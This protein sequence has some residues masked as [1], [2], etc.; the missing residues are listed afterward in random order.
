[1][2]IRMF[3]D[4]LNAFSSLH[5]QQTHSA[6]PV[7]R[8]AR[9][10]SATP[11]TTAT[12]GASA[13]PQQTSPS[14]LLLQGAT[15]ATALTARAARLRRSA[16]FPT[17]L[18][19]QAVERTVRTRARRPPHRLHGATATRLRGATSSIASSAH[20]DSASYT[21]AVPLTPSP[22]R[23]LLSRIFRPRRIRA[24]IAATR[25]AASASLAFFR[26]T[27]TGV[28]ARAIIRTL[29]TR[30]TLPASRSGPTSA[31]WRTFAYLAGT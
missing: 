28:L 18:A 26:T 1:M 10:G 2:I 24:G 31:A 22:R 21:S 16:Q 29:T 14:T 15:T 7:A 8:T 30:A 25:L 5:T 4:N 9:T 17:A 27:R 6:L 3:L 23:Q 11:R 20:T 19:R 12:R 13:L